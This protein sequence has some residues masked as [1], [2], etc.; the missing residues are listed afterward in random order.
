MALL[1]INFRERHKLRIVKK[2]ERPR[3]AAPS[4]FPHTLHRAPAPLLD[5]SQSKFGPEW[6][7][8]ADDL[9]QK[10]ISPFPHALSPP[11]VCFFLSF[12]ISNFLPNL[13]V[14]L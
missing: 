7:A 8:L 14:F 13:F 11:P 9:P 2:L 10:K 3:T 5:P 4:K 6:S 12:F 1:L